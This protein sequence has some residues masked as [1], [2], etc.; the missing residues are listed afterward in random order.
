MAE[1]TPDKPAGDGDKQ[2]D[3][4]PEKPKKTLRQRLPLLM[5]I[6]LVLVV[7]IVAGVLFW[8]NARKYEST[9]DAF[10]DTNVA[11]LSP[12]AAG[13]VTRLSV[14]DNER[15]N[16]GE[17][18][19][20]IDSSVAETQ[21]TQAEA[22]KA[23]ARAQ[24]A[25]ARA[26]VGVSD[27]NIAQARADAIAPAA[28]AAQADRDYRR[29]LNVKAAAPGAVAQQQVDAAGTAA[30]ADAGQAK[31]ALSKVRASQ[32][33]A[34]ATRT[35]ISSGEAQLKTAD[36]QEAQAKLQVGYAQVVAPFS[37]HVAHKTVS[38]GD[39]VTQGQE[40]M[41]VVPDEVWVTANF[42]ETQL[43][44]M[45][46]GQPVEIKVDAYPGVRFTGH[47]QSIQR[48]AGQSFAV[49]PAQNATGNY[50]KVVQR[51]PVKIVFDHR[52]FRYPLGPGMSVSPRVRIA[53]AL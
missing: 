27:A 18:L 50:V 16:A 7:A 23:S 24:I 17:L 31:S 51:V 48:G 21:I 25:Q 26:Q 44:H 33:Q 20:Q 46:P 53:S 6:G 19:V 2:P 35:Q 22:S 12:R 13:Q 29:Y 14:Q 45:R 52:D 49:L 37:G 36:A 4:A 30:R 28:Q 43:S 41:S 9:D 1:E 40:L 39:Y 42:K 5:G 11:H 38:L 15:V 3:Q 10:I 34:L 47:I 32:A 8:L